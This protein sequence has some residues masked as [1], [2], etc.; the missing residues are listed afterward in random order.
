VPRDPNGGAPTAVWQEG[1]LLHHPPNGHPRRW[2]L[3]RGQREAHHS[4]ELRAQLKTIRQ[5]DG[6]VMG[7]EV[8]DDCV[9]GKRL[10]P[11][12]DA[13][14]QDREG[15][16]ELWRLCIA[17]VQRWLM[18]W[19]AAAVHAEAFPH[20]KREHAH[21]RQAP[22]LPHSTQAGG[23]SRVGSLS[24]TASKGGGRVGRTF[25]ADIRRRT[26]RRIRPVTHSGICVPPPGTVSWWI[27][28]RAHEVLFP[29]ARATGKEVAPMRRSD[30]T[31]GSL[32]RDTR[33]RANARLGHHAR[34]VLS[35]MAS[36]PLS[37]GSAVIKSKRAELRPIW[38]AII[39]ED[40]RKSIGGL[41]YFGKSGRD[42]GVS[43]AGPC[44]QN[45]GRAA[46]LRS[47]W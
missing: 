9:K 1:D 16:I 18:A 26:D 8:L 29:E 19:V 43:S 12:I 36:R 46:Q 35:L 27:E 4:E 40:F 45:I 47:A 21:S 13:T 14:H 11:A 42:G 3:R 7:T 20:Q 28:C 15:Y 23:T 38:Q 32:T 25:K 6:E 33:P 37:P 30:G 44:G 5:S 2:H 39:G 17:S 24:L 34:G 31:R 10:A 41:S 22:R